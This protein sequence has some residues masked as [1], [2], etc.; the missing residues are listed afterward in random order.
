MAHLLVAL[1]IAVLICPPLKAQV[2]PT[3][4]QPK[5]AGTSEQARK[6]SDFSQIIKSRDEQVSGQAEVRR[7]INF[8]DGSANRI[9]RFFDS[10]PSSDFAGDLNRRIQS[11]LARL[12]RLDAAAGDQTE[13]RRAT[14]ATNVK[15][16]GFS[17]AP[18][19]ASPRAGRGPVLHESLKDAVVAF[20]SHNHGEMM[21]ELRTSLSDLQRNLSPKHLQHAANFDRFMS[22]WEVQLRKASGAG[23]ID[24]LRPLAASAAEPNGTREP[25]TVGGEGASSATTKYRETLRAASDSLSSRS[26]HADVRTAMLKDVSGFREGIKTFSDARDKEIEAMDRSIVQSAKDIFGSNV[27]SRVFFWLLIVFAGIFLLIMIGPMF[28]SRTTIAENLLKAEFLLQFSTVFILTAAIIIL[29]IGGFIDRDQ[30]PVLL[31]GI[32]GYVLGQL[33]KPGSDIVRNAPDLARV[34]SVP[35][36]VPKNDNPPPGATEQQPSAGSEGRAPGAGRSAERA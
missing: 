14:R 24:L 34:A 13:A 6:E 32:S 10:L 5:Q 18:D 15:A 19:T 20:H 7:I 28:Y 1:A 16:V 21:V 9:N 12:D 26:L 27:N 35:V 30:L 22:A 11:E 33:G 4:D 3:A 2:T 36:D 23:A 31:A 25:A 29:G 17:P 8:A